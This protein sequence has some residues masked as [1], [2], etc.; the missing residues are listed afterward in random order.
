MRVAYPTATA[1]AEKGVRLPA[2]SLPEAKAGAC[3]S[4]PEIIDEASHT[5]LIESTRGVEA[6]ERV[7]EAEL[8]YVGIARQVHLL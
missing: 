2:R 1:A 7:I 8:V 6:I 4:S 3:A 5:A